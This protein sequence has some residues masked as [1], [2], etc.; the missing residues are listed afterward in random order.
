MKK[1]T[2]LLAVLMI[3]AFS[4]GQVFTG[5]SWM[6]NGSVDYSVTPWEQ[7]TY[8]ALEA[9]D[10]W[11]GVGNV[12]EFDATW[13][14]LG[15][16]N[17]IGNKTG[18]SKYTGEDFFDL[19]GAAKFG[20]SWKAVHKNAKLYVLIKLVDVEKRIGDGSFGFE[21]ISQPLNALRRASD[22]DPI[23]WEPTFAA[24]TDIPTKNYSYLRFYELGG[25]KLDAGH[26]LGKVTPN[27]VYGL[28][29]K[30]ATPEWS[31]V[32]EAIDYF[33]ELEPQSFWNIA[34]DGTQRVVLVMDFEKAL[35]YPES[36]EATA[37]TDT[38]IAFKADDV[39]IFDIKTNSF[40]GASGDENRLEHWWASDVN[41]GYSHIRYN[42]LV[43]VSSEKIGGGGEVPN[44]LLKGPSWMVNGTVDYSLTPWEQ[45]TYI[46]YKAPAA[47]N[48][49]SNVADFDATWSIL[50]EANL[51]GKK[52]GHSKY[53]GED[54]FDLDGVGKF[55]ASWKA[56]HKN[57]KLYLLIKL[58]DVDKR[59]GGGSL[60]IEL[61]SQ[62]LNALRLANANA[63][64]RWEPT[65][66]AG[67]DIPSKNYAYLRFYELGGYKLDAGNLLGKVTPNGVYGLYGKT[68]TPEWSGVTEAIDYFAELEP[69][70]FWNVAEDGTQ[71]IVVVMDFEKA[72]SYPANPDAITP[73][74][75]KVAF[76]A[77]DVLIF[78]VKTNSFIG[79]SGDENRLEHWWASDVNDG[80]SHIRYN[81]LVTVSN[82]IVP[83]VNV[84]VFSVE[85]GPRVFVNNGSL[86]VKGSESVKL[87]IYNLLGA[88]VKSAENVRQISLQDLNNGIY[89]VRINGEAQAVKILKN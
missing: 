85:N 39:L 35:S 79:A 40:I 65:F 45:P 56:V 17:L 46:A 47:W 54:Y 29:G 48:P 52:T 21:V 50:G 33:A 68:A 62:P 77:N 72:L 57:E 5:P 86:F 26:L 81:G 19:G 1:L 41:D 3:S 11:I 24:G 66:A 8:T 83:N 63:P 23:R 4:Y 37:P 15:E 76:K 36:T 38:K 34:A 44:V 31:G 69:Q 89:M 2:L 61:M 16:A 30:T 80:Y 67:T 25:Y 22:T 10:G 27:G 32:T 13:D 6:V 49:I 71:R 75:P 74:D 53:T 84:P 51:I 64:I 18:H 73:S 55:G 78:D 43:T 82:T 58:V 9:P 7:P 87:E 42:G 20:A 28:Y 88:K 12:S 60:G 70:S 14:L 59:I